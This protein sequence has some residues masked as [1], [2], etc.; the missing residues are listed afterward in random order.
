MQ[1]EIKT[2]LN[3]VNSK[4]TKF[5]ILTFFTHET[6]GDNLSKTGHNFYWVP[7]PHKPTWDVQTRPPSKNSYL[8][9]GLPTDLRIDLILA[10]EKS[11]QLPKALEIQRILGVPIISHNHTMPIAQNQKQLEYFQN[12]KGNINSYITE[13]SRSAFNDVEKGVVIHNAVDTD[14]FN[15]WEPTRSG[16]AVVCNHMMGRGQF[17]SVEMF[18]AV[19]KEVPLTLIGDNPGISQSIA[20]PA[21]LARTVGSYQF[22][23]NFSI[24]SPLS[25]SLI[26]AASIGLPIVSTSMQATPEVFTHGENAL[27]TNDPT[28]FAE[29]CKLLMKDKELA[30]KLGVGARKLAVEKFGLDR[31]TSQWNDLFWKAYE[32]KF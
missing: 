11:W 25:M 21:Q 1:N 5:N 14:T 15:K 2:T 13:H 17:Y 7:T 4:T 18:K 19:S 3:R 20:D 16:G 32:R 28:E 31:F 12:L 22:F 30:T 6:F 27:L 23:A 26:E 10:Q 24:Y 9:G 8:L 29:F